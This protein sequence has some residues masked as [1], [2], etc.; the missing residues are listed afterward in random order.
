MLRINRFI[1]TVSA[2]VLLLSLSAGYG[3]AEDA[4][5]IHGDLIAWTSL[6]FQGLIDQV[7][8]NGDGVI[9]DISINDTQY[10]F[11][12]DA[13][14]RD[15]NGGLTSQAS[16]KE[17]MYV[18]FYY[19]ENTTTITKIWISTAELAEEHS[20]AYLSDEA[21]L[22]TA[23]A[24]SGEPAEQQVTPPAHPGEVILKDGVYQN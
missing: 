10:T 8:L 17:G 6:P 5:D 21:E 18:E 20:R 11:A 23:A 22:E 9:A 7:S 16:F 14:F 2:I 24:E 3:H 15:A 4:Y 1:A 12:P 19:L 13:I